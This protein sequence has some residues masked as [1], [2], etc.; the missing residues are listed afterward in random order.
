[1]FVVH[2]YKQKMKSGILNFRSFL[3]RLDFSW[4]NL[5]RNDIYYQFYLNNYLFK[6][7]SK[8]TTCKNPLVCK[9]SA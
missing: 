5:M 9:L 4:S 6:T 7:N 1:M 2:F 3:S 8:L